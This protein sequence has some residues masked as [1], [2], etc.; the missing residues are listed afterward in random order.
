MKTVFVETACIFTHEGRNFEAG[1]AIVTPDF[2]I[3]YLGEKGILTDWHG[4]ALG[5]FRYVSTWR[6]PR[7][8]IS[9]TMS[10]V[11]AVIDGITYTGRSAG[12][13]MIWKGKRKKS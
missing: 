11:E 2:A 3:G 12:K 5:T 9:S 7:S 4:R 6:T 10:Q 8:Y 1:G 13:G